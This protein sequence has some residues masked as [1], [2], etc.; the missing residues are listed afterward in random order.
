[1]TERGRTAIFW[2]SANVNSPRS[3]CGAL[4]MGGSGRCWEVDDDP[5]RREQGEHV[6]AGEALEA[7]SKDDHSLEV[8]DQLD[9]PD[10]RQPGPEGHLLAEASLTRVGVRLSA[11]AHREER[12]PV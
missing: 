8:L 6:R 1:M 9:L 4:I 2:M 3:W 5:R 10:E 7:D 12:V 11:D